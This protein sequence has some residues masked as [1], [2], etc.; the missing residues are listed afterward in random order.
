M[1]L[2]YRQY[3]ILNLRGPYYDW[4]FEGTFI[5]FKKLQ[6][7]VNIDKIYWK[8]NVNYPRQDSSQGRID[9]WIVS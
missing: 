2:V 6:K 4:Q 1:Q 9:A 8:K 7:V 3:L 5:L